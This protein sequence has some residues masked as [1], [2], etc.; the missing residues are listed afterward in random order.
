[1]EN[2]NLIIAVSGFTLIHFLSATNIRANVVK[3]IGVGAWTGGF[4]LT[5]LGFF[6]W[7][8]Y[9]FIYSE[10]TQDLWYMPDWWLW[11]HAFFMLIIMVFM[12]WGGIKVDRVGGGLRAITR[13]P[14]NW[15]TTLFAAA[16]MLVNSSVESLIFFVS[17]FAVGLIGTFLLDRRKTR[18][19]DPKWITLVKVTSWVPFVAI[20]QGRNHFSFKDF[21]WWHYVLTF[22]V[23]AVIIEIHRGFFGKYILPL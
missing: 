9:E 10:T 3:R 22:V 12:L 8:I 4:A 17:L 11:V 14:T 16:H 2:I 5:S 7:M 6:G 19:A 15:G 1:M 18:E 23:W 20:L 13:H 21:K